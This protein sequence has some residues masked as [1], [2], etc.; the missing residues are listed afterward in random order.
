MQNLEQLFSIL[1][2]CERKMNACYI[3]T[4]PPSIFKCYCGPQVV[5]SILHS[6]YFAVE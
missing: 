3:V 4:A 1:F 6:T 2:P 5:A